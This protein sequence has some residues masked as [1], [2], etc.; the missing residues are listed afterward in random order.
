MPKE[1]KKI[2]LPTDTFFVMKDTGRDIG[3]INSFLDLVYKKEEKYPITEVQKYFPTNEEE[4]G[5][6][7]R[8]INSEVKRERMMDSVYQR[9][10]AYS[11][12]FFKALAKNIKKRFTSR[13]AIKANINGF[14]IIEN[15][16]GNPYDTSYVKYKV[17][18]GNNALIFF[19]P[20]LRDKEYGIGNIIT[21]KNKSIIEEV[22]GAN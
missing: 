21:S 4:L 11:S 16:L 3:F 1:E 13:Q 7:E 8:L 6:L 22:A 15:P 14:D 20:Y 19:I 12:W 17:Y 2:V 18:E 10:E 5:T 9:N